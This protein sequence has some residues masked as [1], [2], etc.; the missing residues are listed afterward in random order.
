M[1]ISPRHAQDM[2]DCF[3]RL[4]HRQALRRLRAHIVQTA[5]ALGLVL[6][7]AAAGY[8]AHDQAACSAVM[9]VDVN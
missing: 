1:N 9:W 8:L 3:A 4:H 7:A 2:A 6:L 5:C